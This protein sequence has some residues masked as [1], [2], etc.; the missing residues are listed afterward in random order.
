MTEKIEK[1]T[2][3]TDFGWTDIYIIMDHYRWAKGSSL[4]DAWE[5]MVKRHGYGVKASGVTIKRLPEGAYGAAVND[6][7]SI[8][9]QWHDGADHSEPAET[10][11][12]SKL[13]NT[14]SEIVEDKAYELCECLRSKHSVTPSDKIVAMVR[15]IVKTFELEVDW[16]GD[17]HD[18]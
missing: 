11:P 15:S 4:D 3:P 17:G 10:I 14:L 6:M 1:D 5:S 12:V 13:S 8:V 7:G 16:T 9:W 2:V 18:E